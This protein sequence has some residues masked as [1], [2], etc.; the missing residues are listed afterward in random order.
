MKFEIWTWN[1]PKNSEGNPKDGLPG[2]RI[3][4]EAGQRGIG[5]VDVAVAAG[6]GAARFRRNR[7]KGDRPGERVA[8]LVAGSGRRKEDPVEDVLELHPELRVEPVFPT[9]GEVPREAYRFGGLPLPAVVIVERSRSAPLPRLQV[10][11][12]R[13]V[14]N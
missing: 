7:A 5:G 2:P 9:D 12:G 4:R 11:P 14:E 3:G 13:R 6:V 1:N 8:P 10:L